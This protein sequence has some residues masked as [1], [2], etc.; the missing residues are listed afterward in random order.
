MCAAVVLCLMVMFVIYVCFCR[1]STRMISLAKSFGSIGSSFSKDSNSS[2]MDRAAPHSPGTS[3]DTPSV[4]S[5]S[6]TT[7]V[8]MNNVNV[9][10]VEMGNGRELLTDSRRSSHF[11]Q[12]SV[13]SASMTS[14][15]FDDDSSQSRSIADESV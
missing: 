8:D 2:Y 15:S 1:N 9:S 14:G 12:P 13:E 10:Y 3:V 7:S 6:P 11:R 5:S 4:V